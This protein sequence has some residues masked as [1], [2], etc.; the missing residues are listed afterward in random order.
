M[1]VVP[2]SPAPV[3]V[4]APSAEKDGKASKVKAFPPFPKLAADEF[5]HT[6]EAC[7]EGQLD[8]LC[9]VI[10]DD[11]LQACL[12]LDAHARVNITA[13]VK[14][15][16]VVV[17]GEVAIKATLDYDMLVRKTLQD[18]GYDSE[19]KTG[20]DF[21]SVNVVI[22]IS[23]QSPDL[24]S[25]LNLYYG[26][27]GGT[28]FSEESIAMPNGEFASA[29]GYATDETPD[30]MPASWKL[31][32]A[33][34]RQLSASRR[35]GSIGWL[36]PNGKVQVTMRY[37]KRKDGGLEPVD[38][39]RIAVHNS[40]W[41]PATSL[42]KMQ[43]DLRQKVVDVVVGTK[44]GPPA[45][46][47]S[48]ADAGSAEKVPAVVPNEFTRLITADTTIHV[49]QTTHKSNRTFVGTNSDEYQ[50]SGS[51]GQKPSGDFYGGFS[52]VSTRVSGRDPWK[53]QRF[54]SYAARWIA[55]SI[56]SSKLAAR[57]QVT[58]SYASNYAEPCGIEIDLLGTG[59]AAAAEK[60]N[61]VALVQRNFDL[62][63]GSVVRA[64]NLTTVNYKSLSTFGHLGQGD[65]KAFPWEE[66]RPLQ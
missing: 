57:A 26:G 63:I 64:L 30:F 47:E 53:V 59:T 44:T 37:R 4:E 20:I 40:G 51:A 24:T 48:S 55:K 65:V 52:T 14:A 28:K 32:T 38:V 36:K 42:P 31:A 61:L 33:L 11:I 5:L 46:A 13:I 23:E 3:A 27:S 62:R 50:G 21:R 17:S 56:V 16:M 60:G 41:D 58:L 45:M 1:S 12:F 6:S 22:A 18:C 43:E 39:F 19:E 7:T 25:A 8:K 34:A 54:G 49:N 2:E 29:T 66:V 15:R 9:D 10:C 35:G